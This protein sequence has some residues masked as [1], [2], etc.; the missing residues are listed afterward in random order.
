MAMLTVDIQPHGR[1]ERAI[2][3]RRARVA[4]TSGHADDKDRRRSAKAKLCG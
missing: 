3:R 2:A 1:P 4:D